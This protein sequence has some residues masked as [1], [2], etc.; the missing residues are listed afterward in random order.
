[1][2]VIYEDYVLIANRPRSLDN[3]KPNTALAGLWLNAYWYLLKIDF[4]I[5]FLEF[6]KP[7]YHNCFINTKI[8]RTAL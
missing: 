3:Y 5:L 7:R 8:L 2:K 1:M 6:F 4:C